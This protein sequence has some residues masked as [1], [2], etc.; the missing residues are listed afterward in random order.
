M[1]LVVNDSV[2]NDDIDGYRSE[3]LRCST[4]LQGKVGKA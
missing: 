4:Q 1:L 2:G 3:L